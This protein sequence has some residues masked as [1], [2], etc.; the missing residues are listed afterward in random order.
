MLRQIALQV[1]AENRLQSAAKANEAKLRA[2]HC[3]AFNTT[4][5]SLLLQLRRTFIFILTATT[6]IRKTEGVRQVVEG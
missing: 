6:E 1:R 4:G 2:V 5:M 3:K